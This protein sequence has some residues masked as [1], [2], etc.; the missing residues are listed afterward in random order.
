MNY[1]TQ[2]PYPGRIVGIGKTSA[3]SVF[4]VYIVTARNVASRAK[5]YVFDEVT[6]TVHVQATDMEVMSQGNLELLDYTAVKLF[7]HGCVIGNGRQTD[8]FTD[9][10]VQLLE[11]Y[12]PQQSPEPDAYNTARITACIAQKNSDEYVG[13]I[14]IA[15]MVNSE[16]DRSVYPVPFTS[17]SVSFL[18][19][20]AGEN[21]RPTPT[22]EGAPIIWGVS[23]ESAQE[24]AQYFYDQ[25]APNVGEVD[26]RVSVICV[27]Y[28]NHIPSIH[29]IN[30]VDL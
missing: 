27:L 16:V 2:Y 21:V 3:G 26:L 30:E 17:G 12:L 11:Q 15:R 1:T 14:S 7:E 8:L 13:A 25:C 10:S 9:T 19:T 22:Y 20:Y 18:Q 4:G 5:R 28:T 24:V 6:K 29:C 23:G